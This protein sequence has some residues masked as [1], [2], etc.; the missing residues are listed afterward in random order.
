MTIIAIRDG[1]IA[2]D[3]ECEMTIIAIRDGTIAADGATFSGTS[4]DAKERKKIVRSPDG[5][6]GAAVSR[7]SSTAAFRQ[8]FETSDEAIRG[9]VQ[10]WTPIR[11]LDDENF[12]AVWLEPTGEIRHMNNTGVIYA[13]G[14]DMCAIGNSEDFAIGAMRAGA[15]AEEAVRLA[16][17]WTV[18][19][20]GEVQV[21]RI[22]QAPA[23]DAE[24]AEVEE[25]DLDAVRVAA[26]RADWLDRQG[27]K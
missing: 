27:C 23:A 22:E 21:E 19:A 17:E 6:L 2:A 3:G 14:E 20:A 8:W 26:D 13:L 11:N 9:V 16:I 18:Y 12:H 7:S 24:D 15:S 10:Q 25:F 5:A 4:I 1:T